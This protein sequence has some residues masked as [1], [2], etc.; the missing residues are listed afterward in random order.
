MTPEA[1]T[2]TLQDFLAEAS[3]AIVLED[4]AIAFDLTRSKVLDFG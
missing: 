2:R 3:G 1:L 4:G